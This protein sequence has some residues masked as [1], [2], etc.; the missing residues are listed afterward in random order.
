MKALRRIVCR[1]YGLAF[2]VA[3]TPTIALEKHPLRFVDPFIGTY[4][5]GHVFPGAVVPFGMVAPRPDMEGRGWSYSSGYQYQAR[6]IMG[7]SNTHISGAGI[8]EV[9]DILL[10][11]S[12]GIRWTSA[13]TNFRSSF[14]KTT[15]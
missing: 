8:G 14:D 5:T 1:L 4:G 2:L 6:S 12:T 13:T 10:R 11:P 15:E 7:F 3:A 9:G